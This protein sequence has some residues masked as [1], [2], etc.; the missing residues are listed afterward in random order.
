MP[1]DSPEAS[2]VISPATTPK[3]IQI[4]CSWAARTVPIAAISVMAL[5]IHASVPAKAQTTP[6]QATPPI[7]EWE[8]PVSG[9]VYVY[10]SLSPGWL[11]GYYRDGG[12]HRGID[13]FG[14]VGDDLVATENGEVEGF[15][16]STGGW[17]AF[18][19][20][21]SGNVY[22]YTHLNRDP[23]GDPKNDWPTQPDGTKGGWIPV[24]AR[25]GGMGNSGNARNGDEHLHFEFRQGGVRNNIDPLPYISKYCVG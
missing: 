9:Y 2:R 13:I 10:G 14:D 18:L 25:V 22:Y 20:A 12:W 11:F 5:F 17:S 7:P 3:A 8:C 21:D 19:R 4:L 6:A 24:G 23:R 16:D 15:W 1:K